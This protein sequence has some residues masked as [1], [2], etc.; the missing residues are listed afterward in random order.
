MVCIYLRNNAKT[1]SQGTPSDIIY[2]GSKNRKN[3]NF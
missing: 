1:Y 2:A 3:R